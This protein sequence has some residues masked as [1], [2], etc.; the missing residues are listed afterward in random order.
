MMAPTMLPPR[1]GLVLVLTPAATAALAVRSTPHALALHTAARRHDAVTLT[2]SKAE[3]PRAESNTQL[4][5]GLRLA[6]LSA[7]VV[8]SFSAYIYGSQLLNTVLVGSLGIARANSADAFGPFVTLLGLVYSV[9]L[10][11][12]Y[13]YYV[14]ATRSSGESTACAPIL[15][16][17][18]CSHAVRASGSD[19]GCAL[20]GDGEP[21]HPVRDCNAAYGALQRYQPGRPA[22]DAGTAASGCPG[23]SRHCFQQGSRG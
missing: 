7:W 5:S 2:A 8:G 4:S 22:R 14:R 9:V 20:P 11:Q 23:N 15:T 12:V 13:Q 17:V 19:P 3:T 16:R 18:R 10:G 1:L 6:G 21:S